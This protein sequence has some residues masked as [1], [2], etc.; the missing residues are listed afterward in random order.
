MKVK[1][2]TS[3]R[4]LNNIRQQVENRIEN[5]HSFGA[6]DQSY[7]NELKRLNGMLRVIGSATPLKKVRK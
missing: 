6:T 3:R 1:L 2:V 5:I 4:M 7:R